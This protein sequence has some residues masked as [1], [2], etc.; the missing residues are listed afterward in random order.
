MTAAVYYS[1]NTLEETTANMID[2]FSGE[3]G[4]ADFIDEKLT[5]GAPL[6]VE[7]YVTGVLYLEPF[8]SMLPLPDIPA[9][10][11]EEYHA[12]IDSKFS[13]L[14]GVQLT[15]EAAEPYG[16]G[17]KFDLRNKL[18]VQSTPSYA[19]ASDLSFIIMARSNTTGVTDMLDPTV[20]V[21]TS[22]PENSIE[23]NMITMYLQML[24]AF[25]TEAG[26]PT[27]LDTTINVP[28][29]Y[30]PEI[31]LTK[32]TQTTGD[33]LEVTITATNNGDQT[34][35]DLELQDTFPLKYGELV[36]GTWNTSWISLSPGQTKTHTYLLRTDNP[37]SYTDVPAVLYFTSNDFPSATASN[38]N[39]GLEESPNPIAMLGD[40]YQSIT[41]VLD[42]I[43]DGKGYLLGYA[44]MG[45]VLLI[46]LIDVIRYMTGRS[47]SDEPPAAVEPPFVPPE[48][49][50]DNYEDPL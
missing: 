23:L 2:A 37:G 19:D 50:E 36:S 29:L 8:E 38:I 6:G 39:Q 35:T 42:L 26:T 30:P 43:L 45:F 11:Q 24:G 9:E 49:P 10:F 28:E 31:T 44:I 40:S 32:T 12:L 20:H 5:D 34:I 16:S 18:D 21:K 47:K 22:L 17:Y 3:G 4:F 46:A 1:E 48:S 25:E 27:I 15:D 33:I 41:S 13:F 14:A 7:L